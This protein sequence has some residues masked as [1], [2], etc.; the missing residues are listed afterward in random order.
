MTL[1]LKILLFLTS[2]VFVVFLGFGIFLDDPDSNMA[3]GKFAFV[4]MFLLI[5]FLLA[6]HFDKRNKELLEK[7]NQEN[8]TQGE[9]ILDA[10]RQK[11]QDKFPIL[12][13]KKNV[14]RI[15]FSEK[16]LFSKILIILVVLVFLSNIIYFGFFKFKSLIEE[17]YKIQQVETEY[18]QQQKERES[19]ILKSVEDDYINK[20]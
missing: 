17:Q 15:A 7:Y 20:K 2:I 11:H 4:M 8:G 9:D 13:K 14:K 6:Y 12:R 3:L 16:S 19:K 1:R 10:I 5:I 18:N